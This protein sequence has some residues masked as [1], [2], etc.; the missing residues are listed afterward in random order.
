LGW[1]NVDDQMYGHA[2]PRQAGLA[3]IGLW[4][5]AG[6]LSSGTKTDGAVPGWYVE[7]W[8]R[9]GQD[10]AQ[11]LIAAGL[12]VPQ[13]SGF[14]FLSWEEYQRSKEQMEEDRERNR[15]RQRVWREKQ[16]ARKQADPEA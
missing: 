7:S 14:Q 16:K 5:L 11:S 4:T 15:A 9:E 13:G 1:F 12:W 6:S 2:K 3:A 10:A 8:G